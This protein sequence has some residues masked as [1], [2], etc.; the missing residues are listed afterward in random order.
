[1]EKQAIAHRVVRGVALEDQIVDRQHRWNLQTWEQVL[2][3][4][5]NS[6]WQGVKTALE[7]AVRL[8]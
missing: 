3:G 1:V 7:G 8:A 4:V 5:V 2:G 6:T